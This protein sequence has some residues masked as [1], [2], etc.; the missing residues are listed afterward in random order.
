MTPS[1]GPYAKSIKRR[2]AI[3]DAAL[4]VFAT[5]GYQSGSLD[6]IAQR[7]GITKPALRYYYPS[8][9]ALFAAVL[10]RRDSRAAA[11][12]RIAKEE[13]EDPVEALRGIIRLAAHN[14]TAP[15]DIALHTI[16]SAEAAV[17]E[18]HPASDFIR[19]RYTSLLQLLER[20]LQRCSKQGLLEAHVEP[21][22][23]ARSIVAMWDGLP[24]QWLIHRDSFDLVDDLSV[25]IGSMLRPEADWLAPSSSGAAPSHSPG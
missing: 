12:S 13:E 7:V 19:R 20:I 25:H 3:L 6:D 21:A 18:D 8:K 2:N 4:A 11:I 16:V 10:E 1:R 5:H 22:R 23:A 15:G 14:M 24:L 9:A 17:G